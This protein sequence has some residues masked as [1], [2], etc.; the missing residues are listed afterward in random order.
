[1]PRVKV[2]GAET[3]TKEE[4]HFDKARSIKRGLKI[5]H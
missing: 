1:M 4:I 2:Y 5:L 3:K